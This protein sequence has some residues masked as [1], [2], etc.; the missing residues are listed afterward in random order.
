MVVS[1]RTIVLAL[2]CR[3]LYLAGYRTPRE[4]RESERIKASERYKILVKKTGRETGP[5]PTVHS[6]VIFGASKNNNQKTTEGSEGNC[7]KRLRGR[8]A[9]VVPVRLR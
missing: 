2:D 8:C 9:T 3:D 7:G 6:G 5:I 1:A 4:R